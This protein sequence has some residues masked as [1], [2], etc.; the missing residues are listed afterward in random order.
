MYFQCQKHCSNPY[1]KMYNTSTSFTSK[2]T[3][4]APNFINLFHQVALPRNEVKQGKGKGPLRCIEHFSDNCFR[5]FLVSLKIRITRY[6]LC[7]SLICCYLHGL[8]YVSLKLLLLLL[9]TAR[10]CNPLYIVLVSH[11]FSVVFFSYFLWL[12]FFSLSFQNIFTVVVSLLSIL[13]CWTSVQTDYLKAP[14]VKYPL[15][16]VKH[17]GRAVPLYNPDTS[18]THCRNDAPKNALN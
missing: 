12:F 5:N 1:Y 13:S 2:D 3:S 15:I 11:Y 6:S 8:R 17:G 7:L 18:N 4:L 14:K 10:Y 9:P 16:Y